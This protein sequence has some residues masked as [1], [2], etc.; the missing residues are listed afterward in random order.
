MRHQLPLDFEF[1]NEL[2]FD[3]FV[4]DSNRETIDALQKMVSDAGE[5]Y[6]YLWGA[7]G[8][9]KSHLLHAVCQSI[10]SLGKP[11]ALLPLQYHDQYT[12]AILEGLEN[13]ALVCIDDI[14]A[15]AGKYDW[16]EALFHFFNRM[17]AKKTRLLVSASCPPAQLT[18][19]LSD[20]KSRLT[21]GLVLQ[22]RTGDDRQK[23]EVLQKRA[24]IRGM[25]L[26]DEVGRFLITRY[27]RDMLSLMKLLDVLDEASLSEQRRLTIP[28]IKQYL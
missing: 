20:L 27:S 19:Q 7:A 16:E 1:N 12:P 21:W 25:E 9:G 26:N 5:A 22:L 28:F 11:V 23:M 14:H 24:Q 13:L 18:M 3:S 2:T 10:A 8:V 6:L 15:V 4:A 17:H